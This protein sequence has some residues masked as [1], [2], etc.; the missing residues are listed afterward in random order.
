[1]EQRAQ[2]A[3]D[4]LEHL[5][6]SVELFKKCGDR[7]GHDLA[8]IC[9]L[10]IRSASSDEAETVEL[11]TSIAQRLAKEGSDGLV[12]HL[13]LLAMRV[14]NRFRY[15]CGEPVA[16]CRA[17]EVARR[18]F[19]E[20]IFPTV[21]VQ[22]MLSSA[23]GMITL[24]YYAGARLWYR[25]LD[26]AIKE[27]SLLKK[28]LDGVLID[29]NRDATLV[30]DPHTEPVVDHVQRLKFC[31]A[32]VVLLIDTFLADEKLFN[33]SDQTDHLIDIKALFKIV[34]DNSQFSEEARA[35]AK[36]WIGR[37]E[38][39]IARLKTII[40]NELFQSLAIMDSAN[41]IGID[42]LNSLERSQVTDFELK[43]DLVEIAMRVGK[44]D[45]A[46]KTLEQIQDDE[47]TLTSYEWISCSP[48]ARQL[49]EYRATLF[50]SETLL[51]LC[52]RVG[53]WQRAASI[54]T[55][56]EELSPDCFT[57]PSGYTATYFWQRCLYAS[58]VREGLRDTKNALKFLGQSNLVWN[59]LFAEMSLDP[60]TRKQVRN[61]PD[62]L[63]LQDT[64]VDHFVSCGEMIPEA[65]RPFISQDHQLWRDF[66]FLE[67]TT[68]T[69]RINVW[70]EALHILETGRSQFIAETSAAPTSA[71]S[72][73]TCLSKVER[74]AELN[75]RHWSWLVLIKTYLKF[76]Q[77]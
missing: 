45:L 62:V 20:N 75:G 15:L 23:S 13:G 11:P 72:K 73:F 68:E 8:S 44:K 16:S 43:S 18:I 34:E 53:S 9:S 76:N 7:Q 3:R 39:R 77:V 5:K 22:S 25:H 6:K 28:I 47:Q 57:S 51:R 32:M 4:A 12:L 10:L 41:E 50:S 29:L 67:H 70:S 21:L 48:V 38:R 42:C 49:E 30:P 63:C 1:L 56:I 65:S 36:G 40:W 46:E 61:H 2:A 58:L 19:R 59:A 35:A 52:I 27:T 55:R 66:G 17:Y 14:A 26:K 71:Y 37:C 74:Y 24:G 69:T 64:L 33:S 31:T 54:M 60:T